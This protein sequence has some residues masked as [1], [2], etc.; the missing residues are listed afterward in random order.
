MLECLNSKLVAIIKLKKG[1]LRP[2]S[3]GHALVLVSEDMKVGFITSSL[4]NYVLLCNI[5]SQN[6]SLISKLEIG[7]LPKSPY[8]ASISV[9]VKSAASR[10]NPSQISLSTRGNLLAYVSVV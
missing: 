5:R 2:M 1:L 8:T 4:I 9:R 10:R 3:P 6:V 7:H